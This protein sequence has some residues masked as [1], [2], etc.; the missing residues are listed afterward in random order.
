ML[1]FIGNISLYGQEYNDVARVHYQCHFDKVE[2]KSEIRSALREVRKQG[3]KCFPYLKDS[4]Y[5]TV[6][7]SKTEKDL[8]LFVRPS[9]Y[10]ESIDLREYDIFGATA[11]DGVYFLFY[12]LNSCHIF[13]KAKNND[14]GYSLK[15][16]TDTSLPDIPV[17][18]DGCSQVWIRKVNGGSV[19]I[20]AEI[21]KEKSGHHR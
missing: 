1:L 15:F 18:C 12:G 5:Y 13:H 8:Y 21:C 17:L 19:L 10:F 11:I 16:T 9:S 4:I 14:G 6:S 20:D 7:V 2:V 3:A